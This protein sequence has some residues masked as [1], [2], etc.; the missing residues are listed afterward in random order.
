MC[1]YR[2]CTASARYRHVMACLQGSYIHHMQSGLSSETAYFT[3]LYTR[4]AYSKGATMLH[5]GSFEGRF[6][7]K[8]G[9]RSFPLCAPKRNFYCVRQHWWT[10]RGLRI[11]KV[12]MK[13]EVSFEWSVIQH[14]RGLML[15]DSVN[16]LRSIKLYKWPLYV[17]VNMPLCASTSPVLAHNGRCTGPVLSTTDT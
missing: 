10:K 1:Q 7:R 14:D 16:L 11:G 9:N 2:A 15:T 13:E 4:K 3:S 6:L 5:D 17:P 12:E 8:S